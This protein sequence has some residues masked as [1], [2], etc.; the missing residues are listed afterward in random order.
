MNIA[1]DMK[2]F[3]LFIFFLVSTIFYA[4]FAQTEH[5]V[6]VIGFYNVENLYDTEDD[7]LKKDDEF[8]PN[9]ENQWTVERYQTKLNNLARVIGDMGK[10]QGGVVVLG[11]SEVENEKVLLD[12]VATDRLKPLKYGVVH[13]DSPDVR[14]V[15][16]AFIYLKER[17][18]VIGQKAFPLII[19]EDT[20][21]ITRDQFLVT[22]ILD[23]T[24]TLHI[25]VN[26][27]PSK[28][29]GEKR[30]MPKRIAAAQLSRKIVDSLMNVNPMAKVIV[31]GDL[32]DN[33]TAKS[34]TEYLKPVGKISELGVGGLFNPMWKLYKDGIGSYAYKD[35]WELIDNIIVS[36]GLVKDIKP[37]TYKYKTV[38]VF[39]KS[40]MVTA[41]GPFAGYPFRTYAGG[42]YQGGYSD[43]FPVLITLQR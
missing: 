30:S 18:K 10:E 13:H 15:D 38:E 3:A 5:K 41:T 19:P 25:L 1:K 28:R 36:Y 24:D 34:I 22:G 4:V 37:N 9:G 23:A 29:G 14:G 27:W 39:R 33:P 12:L 8:L 35:S 31:M 11:V 32:N 21:F 7:P 26:H 17:F 43:H 40:Y 20:L 42:V 6:A 16:V 2:Q